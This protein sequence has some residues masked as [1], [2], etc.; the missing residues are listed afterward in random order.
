MMGVL[1][2]MGI[3]E[4]MGV[5]LI[6]GVFF[7]TGVFLVMGV[8][9]KMHEDPVVTCNKNNYST[10]GGDGVTANNNAIRGIQ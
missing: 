10:G 9:G 5:L 6:I 1:V 2:V 8:S 4:V 7:V 3:F